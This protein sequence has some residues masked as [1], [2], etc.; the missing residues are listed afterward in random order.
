M[1]NM[2][3]SQQ[4]TTHSY[5]QTSTLSKDSKK[6]LKAKKCSI[7]K[8]QFQPT[9]SFQKVCSISCAVTVAINTRDKILKSGMLKQKRDDKV[10]REKLKSRSDW[11]KEAQTAFNAFIRERDKNKPCIC[12]GK[13]LTHGAVGGGYDCGHYR[14]VGSAP[15]MR[16]H[17]D[18]AHAQTKQCNRYGAGR[19]V[20][21]R[22]GLIARIGLQ[23]V[24]S[25]ECDTSTKKYTIDDLKAIKSLY[26]AKLKELKA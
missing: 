9:R 23:A 11:L 8:T 4:E 17:E 10:K 24:E 26:S 12:C 13:P 25:L 5:V 14:S 21:Y 3:D 16:F 7:C 15:H 19:A 18:N 22:I 20:D 1:S 6:P 2:H